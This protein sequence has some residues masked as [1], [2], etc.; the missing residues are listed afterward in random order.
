MWKRL[1]VALYVHCRSCYIFTAAVK[2]LAAS[3][4]LSE[5][6]DFARYF[7]QRFR[8]VVQQLTLT[9][10]TVRPL[11]R[12]DVSLITINKYISLSDIC[13]TVHH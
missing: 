6:Y 7:I 10:S 12:T 3:N 2:L 9:F 5:H 13:L 8:I 4:Q 11:Y 1:N